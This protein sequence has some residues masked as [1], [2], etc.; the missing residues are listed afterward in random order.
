M[1]LMELAR[2]AEPILREAGELVRSMAHPK[3]YTKEGHANFVT[4]ADLASQKFLLEHLSPLVPGAHFFAEE[5]KQ[6][7]MEPGSS[8]P[9]TAT[10][11]LCGGT[12]PRPSPWG[13]WRT[14]R[15]CWAWCWTPGA[16]SCSAG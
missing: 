2:Q 3:V 7:R 10:P 15:G 9:L 14:A 8:T 1:E 4:E 12:G 13:W 5:Q 16:G 11:T 6:N